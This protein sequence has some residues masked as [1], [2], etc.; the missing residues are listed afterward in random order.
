MKKKVLTIIVTAFIAIIAT[1]AF[2]E[3]MKSKWKCMEDRC[4]RCVITD[5]TRKCG[6]CGSF[7]NSG[8]MEDEGQGWWAIP[9]TC[10][11]RQCGHT[12]KFKTHN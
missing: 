12:C 10:S 11:N 6:R 3:V 1:S 2:A 7:M 9:F 8:R 5:T 4:G